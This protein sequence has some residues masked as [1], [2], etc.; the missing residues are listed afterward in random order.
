MTT[1]IDTYGRYKIVR[2]TL[3]DRSHVFS[4]VSKTDDGGEVVL[5]CIDDMHAVAVAQALYR[6]VID[7]SLRD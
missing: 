7:I 1:T 2:E 5:A 6:G 3:T 4:V